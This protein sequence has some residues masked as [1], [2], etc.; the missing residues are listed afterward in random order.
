[1]QIFIYIFVELVPYVARFLARIVYQRFAKHLRDKD[2][3][4]AAHRA[5][6]IRPIRAVFAQHAGDEKL[7]LP[8]LV[9][10]KGELAAVFV[11]SHIVEGGEREER[12]G[13]FASDDG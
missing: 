6:G 1:M 9:P 11:L 8:P 3:Q 5:V 13:V 2:A 10:E 7:D 12:E 4:I